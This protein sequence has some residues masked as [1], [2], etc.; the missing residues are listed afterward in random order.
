MTKRGATPSISAM[1][2]TISP[3][4]RLLAKLGSIIIHADEGAGRGGHDFDWTAFR[5]LMADREV[6]EWLHAMQRMSLLPVKRS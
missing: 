3:P 5:S 2:D 1:V 6:Q 4:I